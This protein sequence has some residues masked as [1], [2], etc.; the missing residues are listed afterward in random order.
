MCGQCAHDSSTT[1]HPHE[2]S[3]QLTELFDPDLLSIRRRALALD[4]RDEAVTTPR[5]VLDVA[6]TS[7]AVAEDATKSRDLDPKVYVFDGGVGPNESEKLFLGNELARSA[8]E[9]VQYLKGPTPETNGLVSIEKRKVRRNQAE[10][11]ER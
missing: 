6:G 11:P 7:L 9:G 10:R 8:D 5:N 1:D 4:G 3:R 2:R